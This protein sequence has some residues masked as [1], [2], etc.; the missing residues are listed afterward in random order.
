MEKDIIYYTFTD[1]DEVAAV[2]EFA[3]QNPYLARACHLF[4]DAKLTGRAIPTSDVAVLLN[5]KPEEAPHLKTEVSVSTS[6]DSQD[7]SLEYSKIIGFAIMQLVK[8]ELL[9]LRVT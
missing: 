6:A 3:R 4:A 5:A 9:T 1:Q 2:T 7:I 8:E